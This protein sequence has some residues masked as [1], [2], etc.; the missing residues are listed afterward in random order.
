M[1]SPV[2]Q[3]LALNSGSQLKNR[4][5]KASMEESMANEDHLPSPEL[6]QLYKEWGQGGCGLLLTGNVMVDHM[7]MTGPGGVALEAGTPLEKFTQWANAAKADGSQVWMQINHPGR[8]VYAGMEG[9]ALSASDIPLDLGKHSKL[10]AQPKAMSEEEIN[11]VIQRFADT[12][13]NAVAAGFDGV[14]IHAAHGYLITQFLSPLS[15]KRQDQWGGSLENRSRLLLEV[16]KAVRA[17]VPA[18]A[19]VGIK[20]NSADFQ[21]G[22]FQP[23]DAKQVVAM[24]E[25]LGIDLIELSGG[26]YETPAMQGRTSDERTLAREA[27]FL[28]FAQDIAQSTDIA[29]MTTGGINRLEVAEQVVNSGVAAAGIATALAYHPALPKQWQQAQMLNANIPPVTLK[30]KDLA[31]FATMAVVKRQMRRM[32][33]GKNPL[34]A[35]SALFSLIVDQLRSKRAQKRYRNRYAQT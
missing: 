11:D 19:A 34:A 3:P 12:A 1:T 25:G 10:F 20:L 2:F 16:V 22:G 18:E 26:S 32:G 6:I 8:Q 17:A 7:A 15:N 31:A 29:I 21:R 35:P 30:N 13:K 23:E 24:L 4:I 14:Q 5:V 28:E 9:K 33:H 27:Y